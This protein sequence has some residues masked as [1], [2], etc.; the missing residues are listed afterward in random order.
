LNSTETIGRIRFCA[1]FSQFNFPKVCGETP[2]AMLHNCSVFFRSK[3]VSEGAEP[4]AP[5]PF[6]PFMLRELINSGGMTEIWLAFD[7]DKLTCAIRRLLPHLRSDSD[8]RKRFLMGCEV[9]SKV[10]NHEGVIGYYEHGKIDGNLYLAMEY[11][12]GANLKQMYVDHDPVLLENVGNIVIDMAK[13]LEHVHDSGFMHMD[14][15]P[16]NVLI[17]RN[18]NV[19]LVDFDLVQPIPKEPKKLAKNPGTP[20]YMAPEQ[21]LREG[22]DQRADI[23]A[24]GVTAYELFTNH[25]PFP[26][27]KPSEI[28]AR[29]KDRSSFVMPREYNPDLPLALEKLIVKCLQQDMDKRYPIMSVV[30]HEL[31]SALY[32]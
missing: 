29:Q 22:I 21:L 1:N 11:V 19:Y 27:E 15:K 2:A 6:G 28:L 18:A 17:S 8:S 25:K 13:G 20:S 12:E 32:V 24:F 3:K 14:F 26:G 31:E 30:V 10:H 16:E 4:S 5:G 23:F 9:L 7:K